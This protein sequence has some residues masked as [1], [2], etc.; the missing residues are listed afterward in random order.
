MSPLLGVELLDVYGD[1]GVTA[2]VV[3]V[4]T[5]VTLFD[6]WSGDATLPILGPAAAEDSSAVS[7]QLDPGRTWSSIASSRFI[8]ASYYM[9][10]SDGTPPAVGHDT[11]LFGLRVPDASRSGFENEFVVDL[12][13]FGQSPCARTSAWKGYRF[14]FKA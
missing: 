2:A 6:V 3:S 7:R 13:L 4:D 8:M 11:Q 12:L 5:T 14:M 10:A 9:N 1:Q